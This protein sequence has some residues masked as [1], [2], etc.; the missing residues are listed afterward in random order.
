MLNLFRGRGLAVD[1]LMTL[2]VLHRTV[3]RFNLPISKAPRI[4]LLDL[5]KIGYVMGLPRIHGESLRA[6][7]ESLLLAANGLAPRT[8]ISL[9]S[10]VEQTSVI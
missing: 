8:I 2:D 1:G 6:I 4:E 5:W 9:R 10:C 3:A 7:L